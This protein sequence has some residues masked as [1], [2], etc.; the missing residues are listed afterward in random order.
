MLCWNK[1]SEAFGGKLE[2]AKCFYFM[3]SWNFDRDDY[4]TTISMKEQHLTSDPTIII[5][6]RSNTQILLKQQK[7][8]E[9]AADNLMTIASTCTFSW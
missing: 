7:V 3:M 8:E 9:R 1:A 6:K 5:V 4:I 2:L